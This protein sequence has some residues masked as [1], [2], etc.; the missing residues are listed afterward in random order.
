[1]TKA[2]HGY[3]PSGVTGDAW[4]NAHVYRRVPSGLSR[5]ISLQQV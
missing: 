5:K 1:M 2:L 4:P 3:D